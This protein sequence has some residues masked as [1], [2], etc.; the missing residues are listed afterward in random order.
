MNFRERFIQQMSNISQA[1][2]RYPL[3]MI[4]FILLS[5]MNSWYIIDDFSGYERLVHGFLVAILLTMVAS[6]ANERFIKDRRKQWG[7]LLGAVILSL[8]YYFILPKN[9]SVY[10]IY[11]VRTAVLVFALLIAF[12]WLPTIKSQTRYFYQMFLS[13]FKYGFTTI[14]YGLIL[15]LGFQ[16]IIASIDRL[17]FSIPFEYFTHAANLIWFIFAPSYFLSLVPHTPRYTQSQSDENSHDEEVEQD[18]AFEVTKFVKILINYIVIPLTGIY[19]IILVS[20][21]LLNIRGEFWSDNL[22]EPMLISY[23]VVVILVYL[24]SCNMTEPIAHYFRKIFPKILILIVLFQTIASVLKIQKLGI[25]HGRYYVILFGVFSILAG[26]IFSFFPKEKSGLIAPVLVALA[27][28]SVIQP[29]DAFTVAKNSQKSLLTE[30]LT[31]NNM[32]ENKQVLSNAYVPHDAKEKITMSTEYLFNLD[33][34]EEVD[35]LPNDFNLYD[36]FEKVFG[37]AMTFEESS[38]QQSFEP[39]QTVFLGGNNEQVLSIKN[40]DY[41]LEMYLSNYDEPTGDTIE[42]NDNYTI[43]SKNTG[44]DFIIYVYDQAGVEVLQ[45]ALENLFDQAFDASSGNQQAVN[46]EDMTLTAENEQIRLRILARELIKSS[47]ND[48][49]NAALYIFIEVK[50][51]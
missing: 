40:E 31:A 17:L 1:Y 20:Y 33:Y 51:D 29:I 2:R 35:F 49:V 12:I 50:N 25:S 19:T 27:V 11:E 9:D 44:D 23:T 21:I 10:L 15:T 6:H 7:L 5:V 38:S 16:A 28:L 34:M 46:E 47:G 22:L 30:T 42:I 8:L 32:L 39:E 3:T 26:I 45:V 13:L 24:L 36:D 4:L 14:L 43:Q 41:L 18:E 37:F 48:L